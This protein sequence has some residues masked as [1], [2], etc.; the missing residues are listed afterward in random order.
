M[1]IGFDISQTGDSK[2]GCGYFADSLIRSLARTDH[3]NTYVLYPHFGTGFW[4]DAGKGKTTAIDRSNVSR[5]VIGRDFRKSKAFW[6]DL[7][8]HGENM[9]GN[10]DIIHANNFYCPYALQK[11]RIV[12]TLYDI[13]FAIYPEFMTEQNRLTCFEGVFNASCYAD[14]IVAI[15]DYSRNSFLELFPHYPADRIRVVRLGSRFSSMAGSHSGSVVK[16]LVPDRFWLSVGT[17]EPRKNVRRLLRAYAALIN[18]KQEMFPL[19]LAGGKGWLEDGLDELIQ[20][21]GI[22][23]HVK[24]LGYVTDDKLSWLYRNCFAFIYP[25][26]F[27][28]FGLPVLEAMSFGAATVTSSTTSLP[29]VAGDA[30]CY[31]D[32][33]KEEDIVSAMSRFLRDDDYRMQLKRIS[34]SQAA[35]F[36]W[37]ICASEVLDVYGEVMSRPK[38][39]VNGIMRIEGDS[40]K[41]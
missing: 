37:D 21:L 24:I 32:P 17:L 34:R 28:G 13:S 10:P 39:D 33:L 20:R 2:A 8:S 11:A 30:A 9:L 12:Y 3:D 18:Q 26:L 27:E 36:T 23:N 6:E 4:D 16:G 38:H 41:K 5:I 15:S 14:F 25:S 29:E 19:V 22:Q 35:K 7:P 31:V 40:F 1:K